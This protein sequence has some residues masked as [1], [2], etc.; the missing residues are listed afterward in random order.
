MS[1]SPSTI[2]S[3]RKRFA[4]PEQEAFLSL[5]RTYDRL[6]M[7]ED[8]LFHR[9]DL[10]AQQYNVLRILEAAQPDPLPTLVLAER[11]IS[12]A[13]DITR[14]VDRLVQRGLVE[15]QR[16][17]TNRRVV[18]IAITVA[19]TQLLDEIAGPLRECHARQ[20][21][22]LSKSDLAQLTNLLREARAPHEPTGSPWG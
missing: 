20:L 4:S 14:I 17:A 15:R 6:R 18:P 1:S 21:G 8:E 5:W 9:F 7:L 10:T 19:G 22:H 16:D 11:L 12:R 2:R 3:D 13:P